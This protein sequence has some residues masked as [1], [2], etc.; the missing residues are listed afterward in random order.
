MLERLAI[1]PTDRKEL[2][3]RI[4]SRAW[5]TPQVGIVLGA[6]LLFHFLASFAGLFFYEEQIPLV[7]LVATVLMYVIIGT[8]ITLINHRCVGSWTDNFGM[9]F[10]QLK[11]L[12]LSPVFYLASLPFLAMTVNIWHLILQHAAG[13]EIALQDVAQAVTQETSWLQIFYILMAVFAAPLIEEVLFR[14][15]LFPYLAKHTGPTKGILLV[16]V[17]FAVIHFHL[18]SFV[19][20]LLFSAVL[21][22]AY[23]RTGSLWVSIGMH[24]IHNAVT[25]LALHSGS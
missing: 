17:F 3:A 16:S 12:I 19:P 2:T 5:R 8:L 9:G 22:L 6:L 4:T 11:K 25:I 21:C 24:A 20:L 18:P 15:I 13:L 23:W 7:K 10:K 1:S 14:G